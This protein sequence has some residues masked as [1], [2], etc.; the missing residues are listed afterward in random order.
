MSL[1]SDYIPVHSVDET[2]Q[3]MQEAKPPVFLIAGGTDILLELR[4]GR[5]DP[6]HTLIDISA[7]PELLDIQR[8]GDSLY[9]GAAVPVCDIAAHALVREAARAVAEACAMIGGPQVRSAATLG[10]NVAH[11]LPAADGAIALLALGAEA[12]IAGSYGRRR[13][14]LP[15]LYRG[16]GQSALCAGRE[17]LVGFHVPVGSGHC[18][19]FGRIMRPQG[20]ALPILNAAVWMDRR[21]D[22]IYDIRI[23]VGPCGPV[24]SRAVELERTLRGKS[25]TDQGIEAMLR[26]AKSALKLRSS[27]G[28]ASADYR[29]LLSEVLLQEVVTAAWE[30]T[31]AVQAAA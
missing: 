5:R 22:C 31:A 16:P 17:V 24:P 14:S 12:E 8:G 21:D 9:I 1:W 4:Q 10:G 26:A 29:Y 23:A 28:R 18:S 2:L 11:A 3:A 27:P 7:V 19:A 25:L 13:T 15:E 6:V 30:R 20:V